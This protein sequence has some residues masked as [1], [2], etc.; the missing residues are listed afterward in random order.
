M[1]GKIISL[2][3][4]EI[5]KAIIAVL[6]GIFVL[7]MMFIHG[8]LMS[9]GEYV[10]WHCSKIIMDI[11]GRCFNGSSL[12]I[13]ADMIKCYLQKIEFLNLKISVFLC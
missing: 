4:L 1:N 5:T 6:Q 8:F 2:F 11:I 7:L 10:Y 3:S 9:F 13:V 12:Q